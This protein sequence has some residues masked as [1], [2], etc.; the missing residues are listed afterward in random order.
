MIVKILNAEKNKNPTP[1]SIYSSEKKLLESYLTNPEA[2]KGIPNQFLQKTSPKKPLTLMENK[3][4]SLTNGGSVPRKESLKTH[5]TFYRKMDD[6]RSKFDLHR[7]FNWLCMLPRNNEFFNKKEL[8][9]TNFF[10]NGKLVKFEALEI[11]TQANNPIKTPKLSR[12]KSYLTPK[13]S[14]LKS[15]GKKPRES[16]ISGDDKL[17]RKES[18]GTEPRPSHDFLERKNLNLIFN[19]EKLGQ[20]EN[21]TKVKANGLI[22]KGD[23]ILKTSNAA[24]IETHEN[25]KIQEY[26]D[27]FKA[28]SLDNEER[29]F[30][31]YVKKGDLINVEVMLKT[32]KNL[33]KI[34]DQVFILF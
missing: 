23:T 18:R 11:T 21:E 25:E 7:S 15:G 28:E 3:L 5:N 14:M 26:K 4:F 30:L 13:M 33:I 1:S 16:Y 10:E 19:G 9:L 22:K 31:T 34:R 6:V 29:N 12:L 8:G 24:F 27:F 20:E 32:N 2:L 17:K